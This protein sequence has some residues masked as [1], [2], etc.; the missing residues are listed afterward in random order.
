[1]NFPT[2]RPSQDAE[3]VDY[4]FGLSFYILLTS[5]LR[6]STGTFI[7]QNIHIGENPPLCVRALSG[8]VTKTLA[9]DTLHCPIRYV[10]APARACVYDEFSH[11]W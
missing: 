5:D 10:S 3:L 6:L 8:N 7:I 4:C 11:F 1:M 2:G 9:H